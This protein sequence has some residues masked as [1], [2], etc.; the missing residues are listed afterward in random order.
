MLYSFFNLFVSCEGGQRHVS[1]RFTP[2]KET[3]Y[4]LYW[5]VVR[6]LLAVTRRMLASGNKDGSTVKTQILVEIQRALN[7]IFCIPYF[8]M[9]WRL[10]VEV[11]CLLIFFLT[12][13]GGA[14][15]P[16]GQGTKLQTGKSRIRFPMVSLEFFSDLILPVAL[17]SWGR[18]SL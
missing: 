1:G 5:R 9:T 8:S 4:Q 7:A 11:N 2:G 13:K 14:G 10:G 15:W 17:W 16:S 6:Y 3:Q 18:L 12:F